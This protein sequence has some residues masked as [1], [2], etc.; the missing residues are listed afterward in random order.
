MNVFAVAMPGQPDWR[1]RIVDYNDQTIQESYTG[2]P[3]IA[4]A[5]V[6]GN[7][8]PRNDADRDARIVRRAWRRGR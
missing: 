3:T 2:F 1:W 6:E 5:V 4:V 8:R 7:K